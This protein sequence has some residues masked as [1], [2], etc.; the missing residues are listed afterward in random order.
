[1]MRRILAMVLLALI[2][3]A[4]AGCAKGKPA[5]QSPPPAGV[6]EPAPTTERISARVTRRNVYRAAPANLGVI[7]D[8]TEFDLPAG[9]EEVVIGSGEVMVTWEFDQA[10][11]DLKERIRSKGYAFDNL[12]IG[13][14]APM[15]YAQA[16]FPAGAPERT[17]V[18]VE[19]VEGS[20]IVLVRKPEPTFQVIYRVQSDTRTVDGSE[21]NAPEGPF[22]VDFVFDQPME[23]ASLD[24]VLEAS[25]LKGLVGMHARWASE[26]KAVLE[27]GRN[28]G[29]V[30][31]ATQHFRA[32]TGLLAVPRSLVI[33][34][35]DAGAYLE[36][37]NLATGARERV[38]DLP[39]EI[40]GARLSPN[41]K[42]LA[43]EALEPQT[44]KDWWPYYV[45][46]A[47]LAAQKLTRPTLPHPSLVWAPDGKLMALGLGDWGGDPGWATW[48]PV[49]GQAATHKEGQLG[50]PSALSPDGKLAA[51]LERDNQQPTEPYEQTYPY[52]LVIT[53]LA[54][55]KSTV[56]EQNFI[57]SWYYGKDG[58]DLS[59]WVTWSADGKMVLALNQPE[60]GGFMEAATELVA[61][62]LQ[63][64]QR[65]VLRKDL[66][67]G[68][69]SR[70]LHASPDGKYLL[71]MPTMGSP[72]VVPIAG[73]PVIQLSEG[74]CQSVFWDATGARVLYANGDWGNVYV[75]TMQTGA[76]QDLGAGMPAGWDGDSV[77]IIRWPGSGS[78]YIYQ[79]I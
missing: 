57:N 61:F 30:D 53:E 77:Y 25:H 23:Q 29:R 14:G 28:P 7:Q 41:G 22:A 6:A 60:R 47:D 70:R 24:R 63:A 11:P 4:A 78:R 64:N 2:L 33:R 79:G 17:E 45:T 16:H 1:M 8:I 43:L 27:F 71:T 42:Y 38:M 44:T 49:T 10:P 58:I 34:R 59:Q 76:V 75:R 51:S 32:V 54:T 67:I 66:G 72:V 74:W 69:Y 50:F 13:N 35:A 5:E 48:D 46:V 21:I 52:R 15:S 9:T 56:V 26:T 37:V 73:G 62:D 31:F 3:T 55:G 65:K 12:N 39:S 19:G 18:W 40:Q 36:K 20:R 68:M